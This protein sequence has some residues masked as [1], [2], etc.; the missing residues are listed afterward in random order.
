MTCF[1]NLT[2]SEEEQAKMPPAEAMPKGHGFFASD[3][4]AMTEVVRQ[5]KQ[6]CL[7]FKILAAGR[8]CD[9]PQAVRAAFQFAFDRLKPLDAVIVG[10]YPRY[11]D[12]IS[13]NAAL[14]RQFGVPKDV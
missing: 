3:P 5:V 11:R 4:M 1:H 13:E 12:Q 7:G 6:P 8:K 2:R 10:M 14:A 9:D